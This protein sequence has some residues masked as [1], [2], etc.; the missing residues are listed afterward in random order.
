MGHET[1]MK[2]ANDN[3]GLGV[4]LV[5]TR[6]A[7]VV[8][9]RGIDVKLALQNVVDDGL[10]QVVHH[11]SVSV[12]QGQSAFGGADHSHWVS[13][14]ILYHNYVVLILAQ[15]GRVVHDAFSVS[16]V[17]RNYHNAKISYNHLHVTVLPQ[18]WD[19]EG[20]QQVTATQQQNPQLNLFIADGC[21]QVGVL[22]NE[23]E[24]LHLRTH[25]AHLA[26]IFTNFTPKFDCCGLLVHV[27]MI[28][29]NGR[30]LGL[31]LRQLTDHRSGGG[32]VDVGQDAPSYSLH[33]VSVVLQHA[34]GGLP[35]VL[36]TLPRI[37]PDPV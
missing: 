15:D 18:A 13:A 34:A 21:A 27:A 35:C 19:T 36:I 2:G 29:V 7:V 11:V 3:R 17:S 8:S 24:A 25:A 1:T 4:G 26:Q 6:G 5:L 30:G 10:T 31:W 37:H 23:G 28:L 14:C 32:C 33:E 12:L 22:I 16:S 20:L 9:S